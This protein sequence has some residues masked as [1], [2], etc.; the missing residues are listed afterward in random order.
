[1]DAPRLSREQVRRIDRL[2]V[3]QLGIPGVVL[4]ENAGINAAAAVLD[5]VCDSLELHP[6]EAQVALLCGPGNNGGDGYVIARHLHIWGVPV[7]L[8]ALRDPD[9]LTGD[10]AVHAGI[11][12]QLHLP[13][14]VLRDEAA[15]TLAQPAWAQADVLVDAM[16]GTGFTGP[17]RGITAAAIDA[18]N[19]CR[20]PIVVA[21]DI[22]SG[23]D[24]DSGRVEGCAVKAALTITFIARKRG[25]DTAEAINHLGSVIEADIGIPLEWALAVAAAEG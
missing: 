1:L 17:V 4:M 6:T 20:K 11:C 8:Y 9:A 16:L 22:P 18:V 12:R 23:L 24:C 2:A 19:A 21:V 15:V 7:H 14:T 25:F 3:E 10:A 13:L 5:Q